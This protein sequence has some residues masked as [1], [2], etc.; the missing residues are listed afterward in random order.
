M[1]IKLKEN[2]TATAATAKNKGHFLIFF[3]R[4]RRCG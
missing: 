4:R 1:W 2:K 3:R